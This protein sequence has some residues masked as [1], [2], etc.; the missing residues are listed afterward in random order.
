MERNKEIIH[1]FINVEEYL[2]IKGPVETLCGMRSFS[3]CGR[4]SDILPITCEKC[5]DLEVL[6]T[7]SKLKI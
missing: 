6:Q 3:A 5:K 7:L 4:F 1:R 2:Q